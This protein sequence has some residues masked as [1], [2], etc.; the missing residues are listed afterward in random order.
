MVL[1]RHIGNAGAAVKATDTFVQLSES[2]SSVVIRFQQLDS[3]GSGIS[4]SKGKP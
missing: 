2:P 1:A 3:F 4:K